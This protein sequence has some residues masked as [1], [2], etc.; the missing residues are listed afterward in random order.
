MSETADNVSFD[1]MVAQ[2][3]PTAKQYLKVLQSGVLKDPGS[4]TL[5][6]YGIV[7]R[8]GTYEFEEKGEAA[9]SEEKE[10]MTPNKPPGTSVI[11]TSSGPVAVENNVDGLMRFL[12]QACRGEVARAQLEPC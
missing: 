6:K 3:S 4:K 7:A 10:N 9:S 8:N 2:H 1:R 5:R 11:R 12:K